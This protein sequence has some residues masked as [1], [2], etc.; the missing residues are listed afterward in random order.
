MAASLVM[1]RI[2]RR[3][4]GLGLGLGFLAGK[5]LRWAERG[6]EL[7]ERRR[8][9]SKP[10]RKRKV[11]GLISSELIQFI[12][13]LVKPTKSMDI[14]DLAEKPVSAMEEPDRAA[15]KNIGRLEGNAV[16]GRAIKTLI[17]DEDDSFRSTNG[18]GNDR[19]GNL[20]AKE[21]LS[22]D[23]EPS[24]RS[25]RFT[26]KQGTVKKTVLK[27]NYE[28]HMFESD[29]HGSANRDSGR[30]M[31]SNINFFTAQSKA[32]SLLEETVEISNKSYNPPSSR[33]N[34]KEETVNSADCYV[35]GDHLAVDFTEEGKMPPSSTSV[36]E[37]FCACMKE[38]TELLKK[39]R[40]CMTSKADE[41]TADRTLYKSARL[42]STAVDMRPMSLLAVGQLGNTYLLHGELKLNI[43]RELRALL[44]RREALP[45]GGGGSVRSKRSDILRRE[46]ISPVLVEVCEECEELLIEAGRKYKRA[47]SIDGND[48]RALYNWGLALSFR[49]QLIAGIGPEAAVDADKVYLAA[50]DKFDAM[51]SRSNLYATNALYRWGLA[52]QQRSYLRPHN[53]KEKIKLLHQAKSLFEDVLTMESDNMQVR[54]AL[55]TCVYELNYSRQW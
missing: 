30:G 34:V 5:G 45:I 37:E 44:L 29:A 14:R 9:G 49:A 51:M 53:N 23:E 39:A 50:I 41:E 55:D 8:S 27:H 48:V 15:Y 42:L 25:F 3:N 26:T 19:N 35:D 4:L 43:S 33:R 1:E 46:D 32:S 10:G 11:S 7:V 24:D 22:Y 36:D 13:G 20:H 6:R 52:L 31:V 40:E 38:A 28:Q 17:L 47:L 54:E 12:G 18:V 16:R 21:M 2:G